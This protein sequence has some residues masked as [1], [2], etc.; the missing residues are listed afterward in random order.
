[1]GALGKRAYR[2]YSVE[3][4]RIFPFFGRFIVVDGR[5]WKARLPE[6]FDRRCSAEPA[7]FLTPCLRLRDAALSTPLRGSLFDCR[8]LFASLKHPADEPF[9]HHLCHNLM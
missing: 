5:A 9:P 3:P 6:V 7:A 8:C 1:M 2:R 4:R